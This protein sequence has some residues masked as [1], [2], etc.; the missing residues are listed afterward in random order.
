M[1]HASFFTRI[2][3][4]LIVF[5]SFF[6]QQ[7]PHGNLRSTGQV[8][9]LRSWSVSISFSLP[10]LFLPLRLFHAHHTHCNTSLYAANS[11]TSSTKIFPSTLT[12]KIV[13]TESR[14][15][16]LVLLALKAPLNSP[17]LNPPVLSSWQVRCFRP[18]WGGRSRAQDEEWGWTE[19]GE[20]EGVDL[21]LAS[22][23]SL[24]TSLSVSIL[25]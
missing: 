12:S 14:R 19:L 20:R 22:Q 23:R 15:R 10:L 3:R 7:R 2:L 8:L 21:S 5:C 16:A 24:G 25:S 18:R 17:D 11:P 13:E 4:M 6:P 9:A 1:S